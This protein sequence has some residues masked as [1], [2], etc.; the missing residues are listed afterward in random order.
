METAAITQVDYKPAMT[1]YNL[2]SST[3]SK[4]E[5]NPGTIR[6]GPWSPE[7]DRRLMEIISL[8][9]PLNW[10]R[11]SVLLV[12]RL[13]KQ[14]RERYHQNLK[15]LL[16]RNPINAE[17][18]MLIEKLVQQHGKKW[19]EIARHLPGR[20][21][22][23]IKNWWNGG[24]SRR[25]RKLDNLCVEGRLRRNLGAE[26]ADN[27][28]SSAHAGISPLNRA[29]PSPQVVTP[30]SS[31]K[32][33]TL[34]QYQSLSAPPSGIPHVGHWRRRLTG[35]LAQ[36]MPHSAG[37][38]EVMH[39]SHVPVVHETGA[40]AIHAVPNYSNNNM[41]A[42]NT[43]M[44]GS[45]TPAQLPGA[46]NAY[47][48]SNEVDG[49]RMQNA[50]L[51]PRMCADAGFADP[52]RVNYRYVSVPFQV[53]NMPHV[54]LP[55]AGEQQQPMPMTHLL[56][57]L[58]S[59]GTSMSSLPSSAGSYVSGRHS[60][61]GYQYGAYAPYVSPASGLASSLMFGATLTGADLRRPLSI[62]STLPIGT[63]GSTSSPFAHMLSTETNSEVLELS[64]ESSLVST[65]NPTTSPL[66]PKSAV[67][68]SSDEPIERLPANEEKKMC[69]ANLIN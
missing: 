46:P 61:F 41:I 21:D 30:Q 1:S 50:S 49:S 40:P 62:P 47:L 53:R 51:V 31:Q 38:Q 60:S 23:A 32:T 24:A 25:R 65:S 18:G 48:G 37:N 13:P 45:G 7:E 11:I 6:R 3:L 35:Y 68:D 69:V 20:S 39:L 9:G 36:T 17:E 10:V 8:Y 34:E 33:L 27:M 19:A 64:R 67:R 63:G 15:P 16:N 28:I 43:M 66:V 56:Y 55:P 58:S 2:E 5:Q 54:L 4:N 42:F 52:S 22:N 14:C 59:S 57:P 26:T 44:F 12:S 29:F